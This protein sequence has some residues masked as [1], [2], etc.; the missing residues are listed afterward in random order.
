[1]PATARPYGSAGIPSRLLAHVSRQAYHRL[2]PQDRE[3][4]RRY[5]QRAI[6]LQRGELSWNALLSS[7]V[8]AAAGAEVSVFWDA[9]GGGMLV[10][11]KLIGYL[12]LLLL[13]CGS[14]AAEAADSADAP[15]AA[16]N[17]PA[18]AT[19]AAPPEKVAPNSSTTPGV[20]APKAT[21][22]PSAM[23]P[24]GSKSAPDNTQPP[25]K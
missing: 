11:R 14:I 10:S 24:T 18:A 6:R 20:M 21:P 15:A 3:P 13:A 12:T 7:L 17:P 4:L 2:A 9:I 8:C 16:G 23:K 5:L 25:A 19:N 1:M 22:S